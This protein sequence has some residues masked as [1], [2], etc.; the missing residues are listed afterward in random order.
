MPGYNMELDLKIM[1]VGAA[2]QQAKLLSGLTLKQIAL[3]MEITESV[4]KKLF[5]EHQ[6]RIPDILEVIAMCKAL[7][8]DFLMEWMRAQLEDLDSGQGG[9]V[10]SQFCR[11]SDGFSKLAQTTALALSDGKLDASEAN[12]MLRHARNVR[13]DAEQ[14]MQA[15]APIAGQIFQGGKWVKVAVV[16]ECRRGEPQ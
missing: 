6:E 12:A 2:I 13:E 11:L 15:V 7:K 14:I 3:R 16:C 5:A 8:S 10:A 1:P 9:N 4:A